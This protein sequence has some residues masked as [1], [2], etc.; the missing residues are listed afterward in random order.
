MMPKLSRSISNN[1]RIAAEMK[2]S[3]NKDTSLDT[4]KTLA[5]KV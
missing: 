5:V 2:N 4:R 1:F 3:E